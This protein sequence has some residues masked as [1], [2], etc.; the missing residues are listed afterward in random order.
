MFVR[1]WMKC[2]PSMLLADAPVGD[3]LRFMEVREIEHLAVL[4]VG[5]LEGLV[6]REMLRE[7]LIKTDPWAPRRPLLLGSAVAGPPISIAPSETMER[8]VQ[9]LVERGVP[10]L[11]VIDGGRLAGTL[12]V[13]DALRA[14]ASI[15]GPPELGARVVVTVPAGGDLRE[16]VRRRAGGLVVRSLA[17]FEEPGGERQ[18]VVR[19]RG[20]SSPSAA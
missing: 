11:A 20:R 5:G 6:T 19:L 18:V 15:L 4:G 9:L 1:Q 2:P 17:A 13:G 8:A 16:E 10:A 12:A 14:L 7:K 3:A